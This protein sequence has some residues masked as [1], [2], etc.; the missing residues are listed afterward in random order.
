MKEIVCTVVSVPF[1][2]IPTVAMF[3]LEVRGYSKLYDS[4]GDTRLGK[5]L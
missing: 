1:M 2:S 3:F 4:V 5:L